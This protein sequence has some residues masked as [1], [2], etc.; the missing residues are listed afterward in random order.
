MGIHS[1]HSSWLLGKSRRMSME[2]EKERSVD[3]CVG[4]GGGGDGE[5]KKKIGPP[6]KGGE[7]RR[8]RLFTILLIS[9]CP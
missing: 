3:D 5:A 6:L 4:G 7:E 9:S 2:T 8:E 1:P